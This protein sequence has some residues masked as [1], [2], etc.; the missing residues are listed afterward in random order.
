MFYKFWPLT[1]NKQK[2]R[3]FQLFKKTSE[4]N[5]AKGSET[6]KCL[7]NVEWDRQ[8]LHGKTCVVKNCEIKTVWILR[9]LNVQITSSLNFGLCS[10]LLFL[11][12]FFFCFVL[13][14]HIHVFGGCRHATNNTQSTQRS[15]A[16]TVDKS[17]VT[18]LSPTFAGW[19]G[20][21]KKQFGSWSSSGT[22]SH[23]MILI[24]WH[25]FHQVLLFSAKQPH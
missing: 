24:W 6:S 18:T 16:E 15:L 20:Q 5:T 11:H 13:L 17:S 21:K 23:K 14:S 19:K 3:Y 9:L 1:P 8:E 10:F 4:K 7:E 25:W 2:A 12:F 22:R